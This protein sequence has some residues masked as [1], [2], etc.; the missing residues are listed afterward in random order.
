MHLHIKQA[1]RRDP[2]MKDRNYK[3]PLD[4]RS[5]NLVVIL[6]LLDYAHVAV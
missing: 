6:R 5:A 2:G 1:L 3:Q 4:N